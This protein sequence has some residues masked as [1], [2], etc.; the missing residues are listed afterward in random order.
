MFLND[1]VTAGKEEISH[2]GRF[3]P[4]NLF[5]IGVPDHGN[6]NLLENLFSRNILGI[7]D[8]VFQGCV[9]VATIANNQ[10]D[11]FIVN[12]DLDTTFSCKG[13]RSDSD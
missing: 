9:L 7:I 5:V 3:F 11:P 6:A 2:Q 12:G 8:G 10:G 13:G 1:D 4:G